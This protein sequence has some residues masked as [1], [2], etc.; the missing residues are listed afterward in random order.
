MKINLKLFLL[1]LAILPFLW[2]YYIFDVKIFDLAA[3]FLSLFCIIFLSKDSFKLINKSRVL[4]FLS[5]FIFF[6]I[7]GLIV[8]KDFKGFAGLFLGV[9]YF[10][11]TC[12]YF[13]IKSVQKYSFYIMVLMIA[14]FL[15][16]YFS[17]Y[18]LGEPINY[19]AVFG[20]APRLEYAAGYRTAGLF[21][22]PTSYCAMMFMI[23]T[24]RFLFNSF[25]LYESIGILTMLLSFSLYGILISFILIGYWVV[26][27]MKSMAP[28]FVI[29]MI[30]S[31]I[32]YILLLD[33]LSS[34]PRILQI[35]ERVSS[36]ATDVSFQSRYSQQEDTNQSLFNL[37]FGNGL[38]TSGGGIYGGSGLGYAISGI[39]VIGFFIFLFLLVNLYRKRVFYVVTSI[40][41]ILMSSYYWTFL[42]FWM[43]LAWIYISLSK[44]YVLKVKAQNLN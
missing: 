35:L 12:L 4:Y 5:F 43:W 36:I 20:L 23:I 10:Y 42:V 44:E 28:V 13:D 34:D 6:I 27:K 30:M 33:S 31:P 3:V 9:T 22:E 8:Y 25:S 29:C 17:V 41:I 18:I 11:F 21:L 1:P 15:L 38:S 40:L 39:G 2:D 37:L 16:Q 32:L 7:I 26:F 14:S 24:I 19:H